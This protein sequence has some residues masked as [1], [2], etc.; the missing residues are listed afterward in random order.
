MPTDATFTIEGA[1]CSLNSFLIGSTNFGLSLNGWTALDLGC[2]KGKAST[3]AVLMGAAV[4]RA[5]FIN[6]SITKPITSPISDIGIANPIMK[7][8]CVY[9]LARVLK[10]PSPIPTN[11]NLIDHLSKTDFSDWVESFE[12]DI[13]VLA[14]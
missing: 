10:I 2:A 6:R 4:A 11:A 14:C 1:S 8:T 5:D 3:T 9:P 13:M 7:P 12:L